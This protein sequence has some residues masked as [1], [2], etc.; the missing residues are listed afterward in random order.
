MFVRKLSLTCSQQ[1]LVN[2]AM[3]DDN[4]DKWDYDSDELNKIQNQQEF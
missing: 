1:Y 4:L 3:M 2:G